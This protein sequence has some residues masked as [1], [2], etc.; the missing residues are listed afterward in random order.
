MNVANVRLACGGPEKY[1]FGSDQYDLANHTSDVLDV[2]YDT[3]NTVYYSTVVDSA[4]PI[5]MN[6]CKA[7]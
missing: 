7:F 3:H 2:V 1:L 4:D 6:R 5:P